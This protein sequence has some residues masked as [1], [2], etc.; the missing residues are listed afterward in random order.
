MGQR[1]NTL[2]NRE[3][4][5][6]DI[7]R[8][9]KTENTA[10]MYQ[11]REPLLNAQEPG[12]NLREQRKQQRIE[13]RRK[14]RR[15]VK[16]LM[17]GL[18]ILVLLMFVGQFIKESGS[19][20]ATAITKTWKQVVGD[21][22]QG[23]PADEF[24]T[25]PVWEEDFLTPNEYSRP[26]YGLK[27][28]TNI[29]VHYTA[30]P[31]TSAAQNRSYFEQQKDTHERSVSSHFIIGYEGEILQCVP[32]D[33]VAYAVKTRNYDSISIECCYLA[34]DGSFTEATYDSLI[35]L[36]AWLKEVYELDSDDI[37]RHYDCGGKKCPL[38]YTEHE[39]E[40]E[41]LKK[42]VDKF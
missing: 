15:F 12:G 13:R 32:L 28:V 16:R 41:Q 5:L 35:E 3:L 2:P 37:L 33:E 7:S 42:D 11:V 31:G 23:I 25:H 18:C 38:Y 1:H 22:E 40:W 20:I 14:R 39:D 8:R 29:F 24:A 6:I 21:Y 26:G 19:E 36:L 30:N 17:S 4:D 27:K 34:E 9:P 10:K